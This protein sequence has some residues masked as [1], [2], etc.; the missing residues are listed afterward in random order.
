MTAGAL[1]RRAAAVPEARRVA[2]RRRL[3]FPAGQPLAEL[4]EH[5]AAHVVRFGVV[6]VLT[7]LTHV[8]EELLVIHDLL[9]SATGCLRQVQSGGA[10]GR[11]VAMAV[12][13]GQ[14]L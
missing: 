13:A 1:R 3:A 10:A 7:A 12:A 11:E 9:P 4:G 8:G 14:E 2:G 5:D 6:G